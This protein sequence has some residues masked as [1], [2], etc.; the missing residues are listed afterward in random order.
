MSWCLSYLVIL[1]SIGLQR[2]WA[3]T[4][5]PVVVGQTFLAS[6]V[7]PGCDCSAP[8]ALTSHGIAEKLFTVDS[9]GHVVG[10][11]AQSVTKV[12]EYIWEVTL[13]SDY[14]FADGA[15]VT[16][17]VVAAGLT[18]L[19]TKNSAA[20]ASLGIMTVTSPSDL[21][22][23]IE[24]TRATQVMD[25]VLAEWVFVVYYKDTS[26]NYVYTG[27]YTVRSGGFTTSQIDLIP[28][29]YYGGAASRPMIAIKKFADGHALAEAATRGEVDLGFHLPVDTLGEVR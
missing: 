14:Q 13:K 6:T 24:S 3:Q 11:V 29:P 21:T 17:A 16:A 20:Q 7:D 10:Q 12:S 8:W 28:N 19:N 1:G 5:D 26:N 2:C 18:E 27:P 23:R 22:V 4:S 25:A 9:D 15:P